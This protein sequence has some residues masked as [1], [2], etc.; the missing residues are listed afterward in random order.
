MTLSEYITQIGDDK[1]AKLFDIDVRVAKSYRLKERQPK[2]QK[3][4]E[5]VRKLK[6][7]ITLEEIYS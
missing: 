3:A 4:M 7:A 6:G 5:M 1:A 2:P